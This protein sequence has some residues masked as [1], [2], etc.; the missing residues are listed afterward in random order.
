MFEY[1]AGMLA[2]KED[3]PRK[4]LNLLPPGEMIQAKR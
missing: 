4:S 2:E 1:Q 3:A